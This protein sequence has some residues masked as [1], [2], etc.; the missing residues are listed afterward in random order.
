MKGYLQMFQ[1][2]PGARKYV[3]ESVDERTVR[4]GGKVTPKRLAALL[5]DLGYLVE[6]GPP[7][8]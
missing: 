2:D 6:L 7:L 5:R 4:L 1:Q 3:K 8:A